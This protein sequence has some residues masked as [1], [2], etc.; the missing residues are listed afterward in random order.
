[1]IVRPAIW[2]CQGAVRTAREE[3]QSGGG[4]LPSATAK[5]TLDA[6]ASRPQHHDCRRKAG[7]SW[8][9][10]SRRHQSCFQPSDFSRLSLFWDQEA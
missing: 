5:A 8:P 1:M 10:P 4:N 7:G 3:T 2:A 6:G 9:D